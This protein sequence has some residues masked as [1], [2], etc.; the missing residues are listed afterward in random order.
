M[1][2][3]RWLLPAD[4]VPAQRLIEEISTGNVDALTFTSQPAV[5]HLFRLAEGL[6]QADRLRNA[7]N[8][9]VLVVCVGPVCA[10]AAA[11]EGLTRSTWPDPARLAAMIRLVA[12]GLGSREG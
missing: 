9:T 5:H 11:A 1:P 3:Y 6:G 2:V 8:T 10:D 12:S 4:P 7:C